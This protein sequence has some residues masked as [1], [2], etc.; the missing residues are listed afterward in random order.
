[1]GLKNIVLKRSNND[2]SDFKA[3]QISVF[4]RNLVLIQWLLIALAIL[5]IELPGSYV[6]NRL[7]V[8]V[9]LVV[10]CLTVLFFDYFGLHRI[11]N[12]NKIVIQTW[13]MIAFITYILWSTGKIESPML[14]L[15][16]LAIITTASTLDKKITLLEMGL[17]SACVLFLTFTPSVLAKMNLTQAIR[18]LL[19]LFPFWLIAYFAKMMADEIRNSKNKLEQFAL[20]DELTG[21]YNYRATMQLA[22]KELQ[23]AMRYRRSFSV[24]MCDIDNFKTINDTHGHNAGNTLISLVAKTLFKNLRTLDIVGRFGG[25]E[26]ILVLPEQDEKGGYQAGRRLLTLIGDTYY[27]VANTEIK[28]TVSMGVATYPNHGGE[29]S[30]L[31]KKADEALYAS[32]QKGRNK[33]LIYADETS[34]TSDKFIPEYARI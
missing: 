6:E 23:R 14:S 21:L 2:T 32:K 13:A 24:V 5:Y 34:K 31:I 11:H 7:S 19:M 4:S 10:Y 18:F 8:I 1:M 3:Q 29:L 27:T 25:D 28:I 22:E 17:I 16:I 9:T 12:K 33:V 15:Y 30:E 20:M 26:F